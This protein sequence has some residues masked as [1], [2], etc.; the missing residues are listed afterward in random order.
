MIGQAGGRKVNIRGEIKNPG[1][2]A[3]VRY[4]VEVQQFPL[5]NRFRQACDPHVQTIL[6]KINLTGWA[7]V[8]FSFY[9][10]P[11]LRQ[12][13]IT[14]L[15]TR[16][17]N[18]EL[19]LEAFPYRITNLSGIVIY[20]SDEKKWYFKKLHGEHGTAVLSAEG[21]FQQAIAPGVLNLTVSTQGAAFDESLYRA[22]PA[23]MKTVWTNFSPGGKLDLVSKLQWIPDMGF[24]WS[25]PKLAIYEARMKLKAFPY[26]FTELTAKLS[27]ANET[28]KIESFSAKHDDT[29]I[30]GTGK[31]MIPAQ[32]RWEL[33]LVDLFIDDLSPDRQFRQALPSGVRTIIEELDPLHP[34]SMS[35]GI[36][37]SGTE[38]DSDPITASWDL[39]FVFTGNQLNTGIELKNVHGQVTARGTWDGKSA[40]TEGRIALESVEVLDYQLTDVKGPYGIAGTQVLI[41][42]SKVFDPSVRQQT[43]PL[44]ERL[45]AKA[46]EGTLTYDAEIFLEKEVRY[47]SRLT[48]LNGRLEEYARR[49]LPGTKNL[50]GV[51]NGWL[52]IN[53]QGVDTNRMTGSGRL[54]ISP[55]ALYE[56][57]ILAKVM[58][59]LTFASP[60]KAA[61]RFAS[62]EFDISKNQ[63]VFNS[64]DL[65]G[66]SLSLRGLGWAGFDG[67]L[68][69]DFYSM[70]P[71]ARLPWAVAK[72]V[73]SVLDQATKD[74]VRVIVRGKTSR[75]EVN[76]EPVP[77]INET[78]KRFLGILGTGVPNELR[79]TS[80]FTRR[81]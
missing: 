14:T 59:V 23:E 31:A 61:F 11:G 32:G 29:R 12:E 64:I 9:R 24:Q 79:M 49:Y 28:C 35:G 18:C 74:W 45:T 6:S 13:F 39:N 7:D 3:E 2:A 53:G 71:R 77:V 4:E 36:A 46:I 62:V 57:P 10:P 54:Q 20:H 56:L 42:S 44:E 73:N 34:F 25:L 38:R 81:K 69:I 16:L 27:Y 5:D 52:D 22:L 17:S 37:V 47:R 43:I 48:L 15:G 60:D 26:A 66:D 75:P 80:P 1:P 70:L 63:F 67:R 50:S 72:V 58:Q 33:R 8:Y 68:N 55:A 65:V 19:M 40:Q 41:G 78:I 76:L 21:D 51:M 30:R